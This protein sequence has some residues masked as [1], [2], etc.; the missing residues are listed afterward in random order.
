MSFNQRFPK[1]KKGAKEE[2]YENGRKRYKPLRTLRSLRLFLG[3]LARSEGDGA[4]RGGSRD[5]GCCAEGENA[6]WEGLAFFLQ[7]L[8]VGA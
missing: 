5:S 3:V 6:G 4:V 7:F 2:A 8:S 1:G